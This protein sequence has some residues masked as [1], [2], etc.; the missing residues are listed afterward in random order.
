MDDK[1]IS[2]LQ[3]IIGKQ[4]AQ[5]PVTA[6]DRHARADAYIALWKSKQKQLMQPA[7]Q[8]FSRHL[9]AEYK[10]DSYYDDSVGMEA[11]RIVADPGIRFIFRERPM[12]GEDSKASFFELR[13]I[14]AS[15]TLKASFEVHKG[16]D[17]ESGSV[18]GTV[19]LN[20]LLFSS[21]IKGRAVD[22][23]RHN[24]E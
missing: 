13:C 11:L 9:K 3:D 12:F 23:R 2:A 20:D 22:N 4:R 18:E 1:I 17:V 14:S 7:F 5:R 6:Q 8:E 24:E 10:I 21:A 16:Q 15:Q 19:A